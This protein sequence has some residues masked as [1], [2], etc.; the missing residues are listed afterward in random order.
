V[1]VEVD[2]RQVV[3]GLRRETCAAGDVGASPDGWFRLLYLYE[4]A[5]WPATT[6]AA[7]RGR[8]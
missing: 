5:P 1:V 4:V 6:A 8:T 2:G 7:L 3:V